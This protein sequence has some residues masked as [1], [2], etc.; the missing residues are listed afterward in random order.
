MEYNIK[1]LPDSF[2]KSSERC[3]N[4]EFEIQGNRKAHKEGTNCNICDFAIWKMQGFDA[5]YISQVIPWIKE[6]NLPQCVWS[7][8]NHLWQKITEY[9]PKRVSNKKGSTQKSKPTFQ[10]SDYLRNAY[11]N[12]SNNCE[13]FPRTNEGSNLDTMMQG[14]TEQGEKLKTANPNKYALEAGKL[15]SEFEKFWDL[16]TH[17]LSLDFFLQ[18]MDLHWFT[19]KYLEEFKQRIIAFKDK[20]AA[21]VAGKLETLNVTEKRNTPKGTNRKISR[22]PE[23]LKR[24]RPGLPRCPCCG[25]LP[26]E[27]AAAREHVRK[28]KKASEDQGSEDEEPKEDDKTSLDANKYHKRFT[29]TKRPSKL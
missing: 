19:F 6:H 28:H 9:G 15:V 1:H 18:A 26:P 20:A 7:I 4:G 25:N 5:R 21:E 17:E 29:K 3:H 16:D 22:K 24:S 23:P 12:R 13:T 8:G 2:L 14:R 11:K 27:I 10:P